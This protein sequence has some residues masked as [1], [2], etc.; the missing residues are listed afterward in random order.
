M[1][2]SRGQMTIEMMLLMCTLLVVSLMI[3][4]TAREKGWAKSLV[5]GP[6]RP[7]KAM[8]EDGVWT[9]ADSRAMHPHHRDRHGSYDYDRTDGG[10]GD[11]GGGL[12]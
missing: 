4:K 7:L 10:S 1:N 8:I 5:S 11:S 12:D 6:W 9:T 3:S 2:N